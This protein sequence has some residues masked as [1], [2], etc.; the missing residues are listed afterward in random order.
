M[1]KGAQGTSSLY[2][3][4]FLYSD[5]ALHSDH[6]Q[7]VQRRGES[8]PKTAALVG[9]SQSALVRHYQTCSKEVHAG[10]DIKVSEY[11]FLIY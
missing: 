7:S 9:C 1:F 2:F 4:F 10:S 11:T 5:Q 6:Q 3:C 8:I